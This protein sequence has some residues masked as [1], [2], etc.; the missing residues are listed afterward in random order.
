[1][2]SLLRKW[3]G[4]PAGVADSEE[5]YL[6]ICEAIGED[7]VAE[8]LSLEEELQRDRW[9]DKTKMDKYN[10]REDIGEYAGRGYR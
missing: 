4:V 7:K 2:P 8:Y 1:M 3:K 6:E 9:N 10:V 5:G